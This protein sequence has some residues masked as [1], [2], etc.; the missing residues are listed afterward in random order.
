[1]NSELATIT[2]QVRAAC[3]YFATFWRR[4]RGCDP[5]RDSASGTRSW[6]D[7]RAHAA[8]WRG[9]IQSEKWKTSSGPTSRSTAGVPTRLQSVRQRWADGG[10]RDEP[11]FDGNAVEASS[12]RPRERMLTGANATISCSPAGRLGEPRSEPRM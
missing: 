6:I 2:S 4:V 7:R 12:S 1:M 10:K 8:R 5:L 9:Y 11:L 3:R